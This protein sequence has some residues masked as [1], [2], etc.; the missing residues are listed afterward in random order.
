MPQRRE[1]VDREFVRSR[2]NGY[3]ADSNDLG[4]DYTHGSYLGAALVVDERP[5]ILIAD[6]FNQKY[7]MS[8]KEVDTRGSVYLLTDKEISTASYGFCSSNS[9]D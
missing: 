6:V 1:N 5:A 8:S 3:G 7:E 4:I 9:S 2:L